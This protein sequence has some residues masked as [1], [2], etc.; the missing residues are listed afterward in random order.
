MG[1]CQLEGAIHIPMNQIPQ[2][3]S[4]IPQDKPV[5]FMCHTGVRSYHVTVWLQKQQG[6]TNAYNLTGGIHAWAVEIDPDMSVY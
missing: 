5:V 2:R 4:E 3:L 1:V 6:Y